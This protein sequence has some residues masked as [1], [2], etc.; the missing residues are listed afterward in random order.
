M[1]KIGH[2]PSK[3]EDLEHHH[4]THD[5]WGEF[6]TYLGQHTKNKNLGNIHG[7]PQERKGT[8]NPLRAKTEFLAN[9]T[10]KVNPN[11]ENNEESLRRNLWG[12]RITKA[13]QTG[14][15]RN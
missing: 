7:V 2:E 4:M 8:V 15:K 13:I 12:S 14:A 5:V 10:I 11:G 1:D 9:G 3:W 6:V